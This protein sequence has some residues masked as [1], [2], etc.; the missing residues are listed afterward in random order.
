MPEFR[1]K[2]SI[3]LGFYWQNM[4][5]MRRERRKEGKGKSVES[6]IDC[7]LSI[8]SWF[9][10]NDLFPVPP[11]KD[12]QTYPRPHSPLT[13]KQRIQQRSARVF[14]D[15]SIISF[16]LL[17]EF[18]LFIIFLT[19]AQKAFEWHSWNMFPV[20]HVRLNHHSVCRQRRADSNVVDCCVVGATV[21]TNVVWRGKQSVSWRVLVAAPGRYRRRVGAMERD[22]PCFRH[23]SHRK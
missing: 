9:S 4:T 17:E 3:C 23:D 15:L 5:T 20:P 2:C 8:R 11:L 14:R 12:I 16:R 18:F 19:Y 13:W 10:R 6:I 22:S 7:R 1:G 21:S